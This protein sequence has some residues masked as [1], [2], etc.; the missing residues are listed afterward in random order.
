MAFEY[1][2][3]WIEDSRLVVLNARDAEARGAEVMTRTKVIS[4]EVR[5]GL[6]RSRWRIG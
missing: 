5:D 1:S 2:D 4:A 6:G 3:C